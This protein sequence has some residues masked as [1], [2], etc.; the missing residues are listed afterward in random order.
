[1]LSDIGFAGADTL[2]T[3][4][5][6]AKAVKKIGHFNLIIC[7]RQAIDGDTA[8]VGPSLAEKLGI[9]HISCVIKTHE[10]TDEYMVTER[11]TEE[12]SSPS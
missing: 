1:M 9:P 3:S 5:T 6:L 10:V 7:G 11:M 8:H 4:Y 12:A 2:A